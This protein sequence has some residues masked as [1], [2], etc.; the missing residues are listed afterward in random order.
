MPRD[1]QGRYTAARRR[2]TNVGR[3]FRIPG[4]V[5]PGAT[6]VDGVRTGEPLVLGGPTEAEAP[7]PKTT[8]KTTSSGA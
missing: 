7:A 4:G 1:S 8:T 2:V 3:R 6:E 5:A